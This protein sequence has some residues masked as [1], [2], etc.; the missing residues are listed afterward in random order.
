MISW[1]AELTD[2]LADGLA[3]LANGLVG[4]LDA[5]TG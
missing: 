2:L 3:G 1:L 5:L 4:K